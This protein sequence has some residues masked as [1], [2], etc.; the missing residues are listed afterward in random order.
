MESQRTS[1][2]EEREDNRVEEA[3]SVDIRAIDLRMAVR[4]KQLRREWREQGILDCSGW[5]TCEV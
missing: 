1:K 4:K 2:E 5:Y 3:S